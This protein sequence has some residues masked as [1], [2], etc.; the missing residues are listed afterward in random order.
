MTFSDLASIGSF[1]SAVAVVISL[2]YLANQVRQARHHQQA[3]I[4]A[5]RATRLATM[6]TAAEE[7][8]IAEAI[9]K[10]L[11]GGADITETQYASSPTSAAPRS[12]TPR[13]PIFST[14][15]AC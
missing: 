14:R 13:T 3:A 12:T 4:R 9:L 10:G 8:S 15:K 1:V 11:R 6:N 5:E 2:A 7:P